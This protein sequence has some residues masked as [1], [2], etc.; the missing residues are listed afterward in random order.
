MPQKKR[1][2]QIY[3]EATNRALP[4]HSA[5]ARAPSTPATASTRARGLYESGA[6][7][8]IDYVL[9]INAGS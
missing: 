3:V 4:G 1:R 2:A 7:D 6:R 8:I 9:K 5:R